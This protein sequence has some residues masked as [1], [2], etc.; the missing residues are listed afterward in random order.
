MQALGAGL[1]L[2]GFGARAQEL[3]H[4]D[5]VARMHV[6]SSWTNQGL[7]EPASPSRAG[8]FLSTVPVGKSTTFLFDHCRQESF[9]HT[10]DFIYVFLLKFVVLLS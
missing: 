1:W 4:E 3:W 10:G 2:V 8:I 9:P 7:T 5:L 6:E